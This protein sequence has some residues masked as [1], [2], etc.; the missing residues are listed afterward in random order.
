MT[1]ME[2]MA[3]KKAKYSMSQGWTLTRSRGLGCRFRAEGLEF[4]VVSKKRVCWVSRFLDVEF[5]RV[6]YR[7]QGVRVDSG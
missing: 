5:F 3:I 6:F 7:A 2:T 1:E 4:R